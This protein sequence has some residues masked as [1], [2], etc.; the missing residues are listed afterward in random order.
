MD[1]HLEVYLN[2]FFVFVSLVNTSS[3]SRDVVPSIR[4]SSYVKVI[5]DKL[6][7]LFEESLEILDTGEN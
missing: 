5:F 3:K 7:M 2:S 1:M 4:F 6:G